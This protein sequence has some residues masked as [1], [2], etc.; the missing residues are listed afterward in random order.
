MTIEA[1]CKRGKATVTFPGNAVAIGKA[2][3]LAIEKNWRKEP[4]FQI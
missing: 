3:L 4:L 2:A 1:V